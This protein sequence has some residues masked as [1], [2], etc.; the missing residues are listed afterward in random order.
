VQQAVRSG[1]PFST[2]ETV[3][4]VRS[5][6]EDAWLQQHV[7]AEATPETAAA[8]AQAADAIGQ[9]LQAEFDQAG[10]DAAVAA[11]DVRVRTGRVLTGL[12]NVLDTGADNS[13]QVLSRL[14][15]SLVRIGEDPL[16]PGEVAR[17]RRRGGRAIAVG[18]A[19]PGRHE[20]R[21]RGHGVFDS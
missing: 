6:M 11:V 5:A 21:Q 1:T 17:V 3:D 4:T 20:R 18:A 10:Q 14:N 2:Q 15:D 9:Q 19:P 13:L 16:Q 12:Q 8:P 7:Q